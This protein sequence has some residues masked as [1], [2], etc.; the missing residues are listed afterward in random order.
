VLPSGGALAELISSEIGPDTG[1]VIELGAGTGVFTQALLARGVR[2]SDLTLIEAN[3]EFA[4]LL[5]L[6]FPG[7]R[8][9]RTDARRLTQLKGGGLAG[10]V[11]SGLPLLNM[12]PV[13]VMAILARSFAHLRAN[14][15]F[16]QF[17]YGPKS[18]VPR[19][20]LDRLGLQAV[21][22][23]WTVRNV[24]PASVYRFSRR[25]QEPRVAGPDKRD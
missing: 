7:V 19:R 9:L 17:T 5:E 6:R 24:P 22:I 14:G 20:V 10:A 4:R 13:G 2:K 12:P 1:P 25:P 18:P 3:P 15:S 11:V 8:V 16:Y 23:G 21:R